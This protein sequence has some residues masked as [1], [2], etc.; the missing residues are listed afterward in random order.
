M[1]QCVVIQLNYSCGVFTAVNNARSF[2]GVAQTAA[3]TRSLYASF[4]GYYFHIEFLKLRLISVRDQTEKPLII[5]WDWQILPTKPSKRSKT[6]LETL[7]FDLFSKHR[8]H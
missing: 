1:E 8:H 7:F 4:K 2:T 5:S 6:G 3:R